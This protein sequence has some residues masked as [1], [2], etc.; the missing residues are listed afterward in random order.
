MNIAARYT[1]TLLLLAAV[2]GSAHAQG[3][4]YGFQFGPSQPQADLKRA[5]FVIGVTVGLS[6][7]VDLG[8]GH[9]LRPRLDYSDWPGDESFGWGGPTTKARAYGLGAD[10]LYHLSGDAKGFYLLAGLGY[11]NSSLVDRNTYRISRPDDWKHFGSGNSAFYA[12]GLGRQHNDL[13]GTELRY[14]ASKPA[15][16]G[17]DMQFNTLNLAFTFRWGR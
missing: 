11:Q 16:G 12:L 5:K 1:K 2:A 14:T 4:R 10:Y 9:T 3:I 6:I 13:F 15:I 17:V 7:N 8:R